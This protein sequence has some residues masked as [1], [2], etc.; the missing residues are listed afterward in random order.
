MVWLEYKTLYLKMKIYT[1]MTLRTELPRVYITMEGKQW[2]A[3]DSKLQ[4]AYKRQ[5]SNWN[6]PSA[7]QAE[8]I[9]MQTSASDIQ[10]FDIYAQ[11]LAE[12]WSLPL[13]GLPTKICMQTQSKIFFFFMSENV[14]V[15]IFIGCKVCANFHNASSKKLKFDHEL[16]AMIAKSYLY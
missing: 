4:V 1:F 14:C 10:I 8:L 12:H 16:E 6:C 5:G 3:F 9:W 13:R 2:D 11:G 15:C 7:R